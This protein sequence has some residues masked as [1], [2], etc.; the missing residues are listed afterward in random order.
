MTAGFI[1]DETICFEC[2]LPRIIPVKSLVPVCEPCATPA[3]AERYA[4]YAV[5]TACAECGM[6]LKHDWRWQRVYCSDRCQKRRCRRVKRDGRPEIACDVCKL[7]FKPRRSDAA[8]CSNACRQWSYRRR[9]TKRAKNDL[10]IEMPNGA[11]ERAYMDSLAALD[12]FEDLAAATRK[13]GKFTDAGIVQEIGQPRLEEIGAGTSPRPRGGA[14]GSIGHLRGAGED[15][16]AG[17][18]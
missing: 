3:E 2:D 13:S 11:L 7:M 4:K 18:R 9:P 1:V 14:Q 8:Y 5:T 17:G 16:I 15:R 6:V 12:E 10:E